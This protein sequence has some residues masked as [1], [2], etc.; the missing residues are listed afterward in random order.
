MK[1][2]ELGTT[3]DASILAYLKT[4][5]D[6]IVDLQRTDKT[7]QNL[8]VVHIG[9]CTITFERG[10][11]ASNQCSEKAIPEG[12]FARIGTG[13]LLTDPRA[14]ENSLAVSSAPPKS[15][16]TLTFR[17]DHFPMYNVEIEGDVWELTPSELKKAV[18]QYGRKK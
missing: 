1:V 5:T 17:Y 10:I 9:N 2:N 4:A 6:A 12:K 13:G 3:A 8:Q 14:W 7:L 15:S 11:L 18:E 16:D